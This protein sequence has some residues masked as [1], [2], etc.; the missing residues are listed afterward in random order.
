MLLFGHKLETGSEW[1]MQRHLGLFGGTGQVKLPSKNYN[2]SQVHSNCTSFLLVLTWILS[3]NTIPSAI[4]IQT[5]LP[6][7]FGN[8]QLSWVEIAWKA[9]APQA[10]VLTVVTS[11][12][13]FSLKDHR[14]LGSLVQH[15]GL[16]HWTREHLLRAGI[17]HFNQLVETYCVQCCQL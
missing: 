9:F 5:Q 3:L 17:L 11:C 8:G 4:A 15:E 14:E 6:T 16:F 2:C 12:R 7:R 1:A 10:K 13:L